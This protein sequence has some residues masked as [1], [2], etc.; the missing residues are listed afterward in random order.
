MKAVVGEVFVAVDAARRVRASRRMR[1]AEDSGLIVVL[2]VVAVLLL[3]FAGLRVMPSRSLWNL[4]LVVARAGAPF[5][6]GEVE[7]EDAGFWVGGSRF[8]VGVCGR[9]GTMVVVVG[10]AIAML[11]VTRFAFVVPLLHQIGG[12][13]C[14]GKLFKKNKLACFVTDCH[15]RESDH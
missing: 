15:F 4:R 14:Y 6:G 9:V 3:G 5:G 13:C 2:V 12:W 11:S 7:V 8:R 1:L 10:S